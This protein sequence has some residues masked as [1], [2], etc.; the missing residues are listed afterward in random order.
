MSAGPS[1]IND[2]DPSA[3]NVMQLNG[4]PVQT[5]ELK[6]ATRSDPVL[7]K[8]LHCLHYGWPEDAQDSL[9]H[10]WRRKDEL[11]VEGD[12]LLWGVRVVIPRKKIL[13][14]LHC[15]NP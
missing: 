6:A 12:C 2:T 1:V 10:F 4:L 3:F 11:S 14:E 13:Q 15:G 8:L 7:S 5:S 9:P